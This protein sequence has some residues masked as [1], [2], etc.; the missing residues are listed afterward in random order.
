MRQQ[1]TT[2]L[3]LTWENTQVYPEDLA[4]LLK[5]N[6]DQFEPVNTR[7]GPEVGQSIVTCIFSRTV[8]VDCL[9]DV[10]KPGEIKIVNLLTAE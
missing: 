8:D 5:Y 7:P 4:V 9:Y 6:T 1:I 3:T 10:R 2:T